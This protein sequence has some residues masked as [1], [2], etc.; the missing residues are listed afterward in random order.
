MARFC[1]NCGHEVHD[2]EKFCQN[3]GSKIET[4]NNVVNNS[5]GANINKGGS[6]TILCIIG[7]IVVIIILFGVI[8]IFS[9]GNEY[10]SEV[11]VGG[12]DFNIPEGFIEDKSLSNE[13]TSNY[14]KNTDSTGEVRCF[15]N[16]D[17]FIYIMVHDTNKKRLSIVDSKYQRRTNIDGKTGILA[18]YSFA[19]IENGKNIEIAT[20]Q[21]GLYDDVIK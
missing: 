4:A 8:S 5:N 16:R 14:K 21:Y 15:K 11:T 10:V 9:G 17:D 20:N 1:E 19:Y 13:K 2:G 7:V 3:C 6:N 12:V 18:G